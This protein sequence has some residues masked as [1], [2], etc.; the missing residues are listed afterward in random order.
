MT[1]LDYSTQ[2]PMS[3][4]GRHAARFDTLPDH[5]AELAAIVAGWGIHD[6]VAKPFYGLDV[7]PQRNGEIHIRPVEALLD[8]LL[9]M[10]AR[11]LGEPR[12][13]EDRLLI[14]CRH[15]AQLHV[16]VLRA[17]GVPARMR[18]G[19]SAYLNPPHFEDH[20][21]TEYWN[22]GEDRWVLVD[23]QIDAVWRSKLGAR[24][25]PADLARDRFVVSAD[26]WAMVRA[27]ADPKH[28]GIGSD[29]RGLWFVASSLIR[30]LASLNK[31]ELL[32]WDV[33]GAQPPPDAGEADIDMA[34]FDRIAALTA[35][36]VAPCEAWAA[37]YEGDT[38]LKVGGSV[39]NAITERMESL[40][41]TRGA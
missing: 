32:P 19:F 21:V 29:L 3:D 25:D 27:G 38:R 36:P 4:P 35:D 14:R 10:D 16:A 20:W 28:F 6:F 7:P 11:P 40:G 8:R 30:D 17:K 1:A 18:G 33:W 34:L 37:L 41:V 24:D 13:N 5:P 31:V 23:P 9:A 15:F 26:A 39:F 2:S 12:A 22:A